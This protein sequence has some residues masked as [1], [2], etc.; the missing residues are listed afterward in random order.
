M[1]DPTVLA[2]ID[3]ETQTRRFVEA[4][5]TVAHTYRSLPR[6]AQQYP[7]THLRTWLDSATREQRRHIMDVFGKSMSPKLLKLSYSFDINTQDL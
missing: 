5:I 4:L 3:N 1:N 7:N 6:N 2:A